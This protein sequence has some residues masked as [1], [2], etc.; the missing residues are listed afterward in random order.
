MIKQNKK[1][2]KMRFEISAKYLVGKNKQEKLFMRQ[3]HM[4]REMS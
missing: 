4:K 2:Y 3:K 1:W